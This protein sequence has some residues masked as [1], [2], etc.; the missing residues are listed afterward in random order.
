MVSVAPSISRDRRGRRRFSLHSPSLSRGVVVPRGKA[1]PYLEGMHARTGGIDTGVQAER[2]REEVARAAER[3]GRD[4]AG[5]TVV[6]VTKGH[7][8]EVVEAAL[9]AGFRNLGENRVEALVER[10]A[11]GRELEG[12]EYPDGASPRWH[13]IGRLQRRQAPELHG[14]A[15]LVQSVDSLRLAERLDRTLPEGAPPL[16]ILVQVNT[17]GEESKTGLAPEELPEAMGQILEL[18]GV[19]VRGLMTMAPFDGSEGRIRGT[20]RGLRSLHEALLREE[21][22]YAGDILSMGMSNDYAWAVEE[23]STMIRL[24]T[25]LFG[26]RAG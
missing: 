4:P 21:G 11:R 3:A 20:F 14:M 5:I 26:E 10:A 1:S 16:D 24:G 2:V 25:V 23:G 15:H 13:M 12:V 22:G 18:P 7:P 9:R 17:S 8:F 6:A 19:R